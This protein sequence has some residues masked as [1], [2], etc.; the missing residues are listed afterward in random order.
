MATAARIATG[1]WIVLFA[2]LTLIA[3][4]SQLP[5]AIKEAPANNLSLAEVRATPDKFIG[6]FVRWGGI[7]AKVENK[8]TETWVEIVD[9]DLSR[10]GQPR[11]NDQSSGRFLARVDGFLDPLV[12]AKGREI[13]ISGKVEQSIVNKIGDFTY[14]FPVIAVVQFYLWQ[15]EPTVIYYDSWPNWFYDPWYPYYRYPYRHWHSPP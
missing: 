13:T 9:K 6:A 12:Y 11:S 15:P 4:A 1:Q 7:I 14:L 3:C 10:W 8:E 2:C 5:P